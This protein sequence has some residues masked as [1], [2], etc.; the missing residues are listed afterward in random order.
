MTVDPV[1]F[2]RYSGIGAGSYV[3]PVPS[4]MEAQ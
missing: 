4:S 2:A 1:Q 3:S